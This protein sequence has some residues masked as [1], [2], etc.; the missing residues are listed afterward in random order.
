[1]SGRNER[2][3]NLSREELERLKG[4]YRGGYR[5]DRRQVGN[6]PLLFKRAAA[7]RKRHAHEIK[8]QDRGWEASA[9]LARSEDEERDAALRESQ[10]ASGPT[11]EELREHQSQ[12][13]SESRKKDTSLY[14]PAFLDVV[15]RRGRASSIPQPKASLRGQKF[16]RGRVGRPDRRQQIQELNRRQEIEQWKALPAPV[17]KSRWSQMPGH[18]E[19]VGTTPSPRSLVTRVSTAER[20]LLATTPQTP[21]LAELTPDARDVVLARRDMGQMSPVQARL[22][23]H[24]DP[25][26][27]KKDVFSLTQG[28]KHMPDTP[29]IDADKEKDREQAETA[30]MRELTSTPE[31]RLQEAKPLTP[32]YTTPEQTPEPQVEETFSASDRETSPEQKED[33]IRPTTPP[34][35]ETTRF[36]FS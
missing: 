6:T 17:A 19:L 2:F 12:Q 25:E 13:S 16:I 23:A 10:R 11:L 24:E 34:R 5:S 27:A 29:E 32:T 36:Y 35:P 15:N 4:Q 22:V 33:T 9:G 3:S 20:E 21:P 14:N 8:E 1:M 26:A 28:Q 31:E 18:D 30:R 7:Q